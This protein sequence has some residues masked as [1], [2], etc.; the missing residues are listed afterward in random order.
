MLRPLLLHLSHA[1][2]ARNLVTPFHFARRAAA[3]FVAG[4][5]LAEAIAAVRALNAKG[6]NA[7]LDH[8]G[9][10]VTTAADATRATEDYLFALE[11]IAASGIRSNI[12]LKLTQLGLEV[13]EAICKHNL[14]RILEKAQATQN[15]VR[16]DMESTAYTDRTLAVFGALHREFDNLGLVLQAYLYRTEK[17]L[18]ALM[19]EKAPIRLCKGA[20]DEPPDKAFPRKADV[21]ANYLKLAR[22][23]LD[24]AWALPPT[25]DP[26][27]HPPLAA[28]AT[29]DEKMIV[30]AKMYAAAAARKISRG[31]FEF[32][33]L[34]GI[35]RDLQEQLAAEGYQ[36]R[37]YV[38]YGTEWYPYFMRRLAE[39]PANGW[40]FLS[41]LLRG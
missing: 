1:R 18:I 40:F 33:M 8:L 21:D 36:V 27:R 20:Y 35:R 26:G 22:N 5:T 30:A 10:N 3:R 31:Y 39:R 17:D 24:H 15:F 6:L 32:Q 12:S 28:L 7:S 2:W 41:Q 11:Q 14:R 37:I 38:P 25:A 13:D 29:H 9:E 23:L 34:Y 4:E 19:E 16:L